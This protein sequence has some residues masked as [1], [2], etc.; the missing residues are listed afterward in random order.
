LILVGVARRPRSPPRAV[1]SSCRPARGSPHGARLGV[2]RWRYHPQPHP[3]SHMGG[4][5]DGGRYHRGAQDHN[6]VPRPPR[7]GGTNT[8]TAA[9]VP[10]LGSRNVRA[11]ATRT[12]PGP[13]PRVL[14]AA[15]GVPKIRT[16]TGNHIFRAT[17]S[18]FDN[19]ATAID[20]GAELG[21]RLSGYKA[22]VR[23]KSIKAN[24]RTTRFKR[25]RKRLAG[26]RAAA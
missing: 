20:G 11:L 19:G 9:L 23:R 18:G 26:V 10:H 21:L 13:R 12:A 22:F 14:R 4:D 16:A 8:I 1:R 15:G 6:I 17:G 7:A 3:H 5:P 2:L 24:L 25:S